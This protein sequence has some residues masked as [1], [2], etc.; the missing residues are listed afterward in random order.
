[1]GAY[2]LWTIS[3]LIIVF[4]HLVSSYSQS[5]YSLCFESDNCY[6]LTSRPLVWANSYYDA[7]NEDEAPAPI[8]RDQDEDDVDIARIIDWKVGLKGKE[9][10]EKL[11][12]LC[13]QCH[14]I[15]LHFKTI[16]SGCALESYL[17]S[18]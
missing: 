2:D 16:R 8:F 11:E 12:S 9:R 14:Y 7:L 15:S 1:M 6:L 5:P 13:C 17:G 18:T 10:K 3:G 4:I